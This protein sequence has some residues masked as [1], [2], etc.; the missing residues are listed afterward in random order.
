M[1]LTGLQSHTSNFLDFQLREEKKWNL[2]FVLS[3]KKILSFCNV[4]W[5]CYK[6]QR[7][8]CV[9]GKFSFLWEFSSNLAS[10]AWHVTWDFLISIL[11]MLFFGWS[12]NRN[13]KQ[14]NHIPGLKIKKRYSY[15]NLRNCDLFIPSDCH[16][17][18]S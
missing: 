15:H 17:Y 10:M 3:L 1:L 16:Q 4:K 8:L 18:I 2:F 5:N 6:S 9:R 14:K 11:E 13:N 7:E 12:F